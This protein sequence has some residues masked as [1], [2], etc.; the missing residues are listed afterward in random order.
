MRRKIR[1]KHTLVVFRPS[2]ALSR[3]KEKLRAIEIER[4]FVDQQESGNLPE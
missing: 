3:R 1:A 4:L 2:V